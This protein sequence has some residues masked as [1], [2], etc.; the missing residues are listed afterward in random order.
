[1]KAV[2]N[3]TFIKHL[4]WRYATKKF[5]PTRKLSPEDVQTLEQSLVLAPSSF[6]LQPW[7]FIV[8][9]DAARRE[10]L[11]AASWGQRQVV[12]AS[13]LF[14]F[15]IRKNLSS[16][17]VDRSLARVTEVRGVPASALEQYR[18]MIVG[19]IQREGFDLDGW[20]TRQVYI[21]LGGFLTAAAML[22]IDACPMEGIDPAQYDAI[23]GLEKHGYATVCAC[24]AGY[25]AADCK[26][27]ELPKVRFKPEEVVAHI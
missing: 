11:L 17:D 8:V 23:L 12:D 27:A 16:A 14:V 6:G 19:F 20:A 22:G 4:N 18:Q 1:M 5:D 9:D 13:H 15:T 3:E 2:Q 26:Y 7:K 10:K 25:R 21:A 24:P